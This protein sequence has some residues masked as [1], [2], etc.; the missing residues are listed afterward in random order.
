M[1]SVFPLLALALGL[2]ASACGGA[3]SSGTASGTTSSGSSQSLISAA[4]TKTADAGSARMA[5]KATFDGPTSG[6]MTGEGA[7][8]KRQGHLTLDMS[9]LSGTG[10]VL[11]GGKA[12][13][14]F[15][16]LVYYVKLPG[17]SA[18]PLPPGKEWFKIDLGQLSQ[19]QGL[20][21]GQLT[22]LNQSD[23]SQALDFLRGASDDFE[24]VGTEEVRGVSTT[25]YKGTIDLAK[26]AEDAPADI[27]EEYRKLAQLA[28]STKVPME[29]WVDGDGLVRRIR[30]EQTLDENSTMTMEEEFYD[31][32]ADVDVTPPPD[33]DVVDLTALL[34]MS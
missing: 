31:F 34:G 22:Q 16:Q 13:L 4:G 28:P 15:D 1:R 33:D 27:A 7:F 8:A 21:L 26:V 19:T 24:R 20:N 23:P 11:P 18:L 30:F 6:S 29:V 3:S 25:R 5:F 2:A 17:T 14:V 9:G 10:A 12:E 32:G